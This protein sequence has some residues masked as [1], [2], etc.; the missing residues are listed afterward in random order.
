M[1]NRRLWSKSKRIDMRGKIDSGELRFAPPP[2]QYTLSSAGFSGE[3]SVFFLTDLYEASGYVLIVS[4]IPQ[5]EIFLSASIV[6]DRST[7]V[8]SGKSQFLPAPDPHLRS[9]PTF[10][11][12]NLRPS[13][14]L[15]FHF[16]LFF[17]VI[18]TILILSWMAFTV[19]LD[20]GINTASQIYSDYAVGE[21]RI[22]KRRLELLRGIVLEREAIRKTNLLS[23][24]K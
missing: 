1:R 7:Y 11:V 22:G 23:P 24:E 21:R 4:Y 18:T 10:P 6:Y 15:P 2:L 5:V 17:S 13:P 16:F 19:Y 12:H 14:R 9:S 20:I 8:T 3:R